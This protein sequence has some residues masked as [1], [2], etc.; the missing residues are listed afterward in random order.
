MYI[1][2][3]FEHN[4]LRFQKILFDRL[5]R[6]LQTYEKGILEYWNELNL[7]IQ[8]QLK[9]E[10]NLHFKFQKIRKFDEQ[11]A[12]FYLDPKST[13]IYFLFQWVPLIKWFTYSF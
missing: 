13:T 4:L 1:D 6:T 7:S 12:E 10:K 3:G 8:I 5:H 9:N 11:I 2:E